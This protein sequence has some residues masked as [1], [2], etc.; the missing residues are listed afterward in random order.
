MA[1]T[2]GSDGLKSFYDRLGF[3]D[4]APIDLPERGSPLRPNPWREINTLTASFGHGIAISPVHLVRAAAALV[5]G[6]IL[7]RPHL[8]IGDREKTLSPAPVGPRVIKPQTSQQIRKLMELVVADGTGSKAY[9][10]GYNVGGKTG[11]AE[12]IAGGGYN[13]KALLSS[14]LGVFPIDNPR[15]AVLAILDEPQA[16]KDTFGYATGGWTAAPVVA[17]VIEQMGPLYQI[18][19]DFDAGRDIKKELAMYLKEKTGGEGLAAVGTDR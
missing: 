16:T 2:I 10:E 1:L 9:V 3:F 6:G 11:T 8:I 18:P 4:R 12:K 14:F 5:N 7:V 17:R 19:P 13:K 15:Y